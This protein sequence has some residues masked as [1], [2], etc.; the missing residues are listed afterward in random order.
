[1]SKFMSPASCVSYK[2]TRHKKSKDTAG[3]KYI[4]FASLPIG[5]EYAA[6]ERRVFYDDNGEVVYDKLLEF[7]YGFV[8]NTIGRDGDEID[9]ITGPVEDPEHVYVIDMIDLGPD[10]SK[11]ENEDKA[12]LG[13]DSAESAKNAFF[14]MYPRNFFGGMVKMR[15]EE[16]QDAMRRGVL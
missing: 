15:L 4:S 12:M 11:R 14:T 5:I 3:I 2:E 1:M 6:G 10:V 13:F 8:Q 7:P 16:F 9:V